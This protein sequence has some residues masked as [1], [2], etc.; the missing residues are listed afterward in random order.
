MHIK[1][2][3][4]DMG[5]ILFD[6]VKRP[7]QTTLAGDK[8]ARLV[9]PLVEGIDG[10]A[11]STSLAE[12][13][14]PVSVVSTH[15][16]IPHALL[17][18]VQAFRAS[19]PHAHLRIRAGHRSQVLQLVA[20]GDVDLGIVPGPE[21]SPEFD[22]HPLF[23]YDRVLITPLE[24]PLLKQPFPSLYQIAQ[25]PLILMGP[26]SYTRSMLQT[27]FQRKG[28][29]YDVVVELD[30]MD[31]IKE[32]VAVGMGISVG[33]L[34]A[35]ELKDRERMGVVDLGHL[36]PIEQAGSVT[37]RGKTISKPTRNFIEVMER[38][39]APGGAANLP[40]S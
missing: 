28:L 25:W 27:E 5:M 32:Y 16:I 8:L 17:T 15:E 36:L 18:T 26:Q 3:E 19:Y 23:R 29:A 12:E 13:E 37:L 39:L 34:M 20:S 1:R 30:S 9:T 14:G 10:L 11:A 7:I 31:M 40:R 21:R 22:F 38:T 6:R 33:P 24:H 35:I 4:E 2:L